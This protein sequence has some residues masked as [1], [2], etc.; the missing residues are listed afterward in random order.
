MIFLSA[1]CQAAGRD[2]PVADRPLPHERQVLQ[3]RNPERNSPGLFQNLAGA[4][5]PAPAG[6]F[7]KTP[8]SFFF[9]PDCTVGSGF[10][11]DQPPMAG[12]GLI[13][14]PFRKNSFTAGRE[15]HP[16]LKNVT[17]YVVAY[18]AFRRCDQLPFYHIRNWPSVNSAAHFFRQCP[19][20]GKNAS[21]SP[22]FRFS[23]PPVCP[24]RMSLFSL[25]RP[26][27]GI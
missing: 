15:L 11:P 10:Q 16:T 23:F 22:I 24:D 5:L 25:R 2:V 3:K 1:A 4:S 8:A 20:S 12:R 14:L 17:F 27:G 19:R 21:V 9:H 6:A 18:A 7:R 13:C 26:C